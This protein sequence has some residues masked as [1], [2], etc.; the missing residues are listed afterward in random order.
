LLVGRDGTASLVELPAGLPLG[1]GES[2]E[3]DTAS[4]KSGDRLLMYTDG[5]SEARDREGVF[6]PVL[7][8]HRWSRGAR[9]RTRSTR[10]STRYADTSRTAS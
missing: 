6:L 7:D 10:C 1:L 5:L 8:W 4:I 9:S 3:A 2:Y